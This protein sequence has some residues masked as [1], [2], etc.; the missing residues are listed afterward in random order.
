MFRV[1]NL[2][3]ISQAEP[4][5]SHYIGLFVFQRPKQSIW[6]EFRGGRNLFKCR[7]NTG[8]SACGVVKRLKAV[9]IDPQPDASGTAWQWVRHYVTLCRSISAAMVM[10]SSNKDE[11]LKGLILAL[12]PNLLFFIV[13]SQS[14]IF[15]TISHQMKCFIFIHLNF[16]LKSDLIFLKNLW[17]Y[18]LQKYL[19]VGRSKNFYINQI[20]HSS[21]LT[22]LLKLLEQTEWLI[23]AASIYADCAYVIFQVNENYVH[24]CS[25]FGYCTS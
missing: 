22:I 14:W 1:L 10:K 3:D 18:L 25:K 17:I 8:Q 13:F 19:Q 9:L 2:S 24:S 4:L 12:V 21:K 23:L 7:K 5:A 11:T 16:W 6:I 20:S 15:F